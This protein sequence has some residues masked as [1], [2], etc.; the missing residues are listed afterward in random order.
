[1]DSE[2]L[3]SVIIPT[4]NR[5]RFLG[6][7]VDSCL[8]QTHPKREI[9][10]VDDG[11]DDDTERLLRRA[12]GS[13]IRYIYQ[14]NQG[15][16]IAR[17]TG[18]AAARG[19]FIHF[20]DADDQL[21]PRK[22]EICLDV[23]RREP[24]VAVVYTHFQQ[25]ASD[26]AS[27]LP[28]PA[29]AR[30]GDEIFCEMLRQTGCHILLSASM[31]KTAALRAVGGF[32]DDPEFRSAEDWDLLLRLAAR[33]RFVGIDQPLVRRR[34][35]GDMIS[36]HKLYGA[37]GR[38]KTIQRARAYGGER[39]MTAADYDRL[40]AARHHVYALALWRAG[41]RTLA[42]SHFHSAAALF[43]PEAPQRRLYALL[44]L[45]LPPASMAMSQALARAIRGLLRINR[46]H[47]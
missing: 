34:A 13:A 12:Y 6:D 39:C 16:G 27:P 47:S 4:Y 31:Y 7:A 18:I 30:Y 22:I 36:D 23:F 38:L 45:C 11:G 5:A 19:E 29:F 3:V 21:L 41:Q 25:V 46:R 40:E 20:L 43:P 24:D 33:F 2:P 14:R 10:V 15:P 26:G 9:I 1:M 44:T 42:R 32:A 17:N 37:L 35:H 8:A 28:T